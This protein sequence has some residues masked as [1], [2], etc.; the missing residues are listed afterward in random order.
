MFK[1]KIGVKRKLKYL[2]FLHTTRHIAG[3]PS[4]NFQTIRAYF[5][6]NITNNALFKNQNSGIKL[7][8]MGFWVVGL[9]SDSPMQ[10]GT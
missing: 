3:V 7:N 5:H 1:D 9:N 10:T 6:A 2:F 8:W 4:T